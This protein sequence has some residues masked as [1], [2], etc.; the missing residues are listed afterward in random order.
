MR[1]DLVFDTGRDLIR[2]QCKW[3]TRYGDVV[4]GRYYANR[5]AR[6]GMRRS[7][8]DT[9]EVDAFAMYCAE[10]GRC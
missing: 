3:A 8:Y 6:E 9:S 2:V 5:R 4:I 1:Y 10:L 7:V